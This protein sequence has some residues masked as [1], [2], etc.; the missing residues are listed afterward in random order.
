MLTVHLAANKQKVTGE[1]SFMTACGVSLKTVIDTNLVTDMDMLVDYLCCQLGIP[2]VPQLELCDNNGDKIQ[3]FA[4]LMS[5][6]AVC[7]VIVP[8][9]D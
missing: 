8:A 5:A 1:Q 2:H 6:T 7:L 9:P 4:H 3:S